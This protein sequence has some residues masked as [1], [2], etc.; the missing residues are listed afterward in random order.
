M[1][2][3]LTELPM[4]K[5]VKPLQLLKALSP[6]EVT[7]SGMVSEPVK[8]PQYWKAELPIEVTA[9]GMVNDVKPLQL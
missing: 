2:I 1:F 4:V 5:D 6:I 9:F 3:K 8:L 7:A